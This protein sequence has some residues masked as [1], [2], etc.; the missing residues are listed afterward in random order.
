MLEEMA[1]TA[2][3][4]IGA[5]TH[6]HFE[7]PSLNDERVEAELSRCDELLKGRLGIRVEHF[8]Y[9]RG[10]WN[11]RVERFVKKRY[12]SA[13][14][15]GGG[16]VNRGQWDRYRLPRIPVQGSDGMR[17][18]E[19]RISGDLRYEELTV[20]MLKHLRGMGRDHRQGMQ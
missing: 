18:F 3:V 11:E 2:L 19:S 7:L 4:T 9:P 15:V 10:A 17:W 13:V 12:R 14:H 16:V 5:H 6:G 8:A 20:R 1:E